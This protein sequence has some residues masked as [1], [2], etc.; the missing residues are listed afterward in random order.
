M[1]ASELKPENRFFGMFVGR[2]KSGKTVAAASFPKPMIILDGDLRA[3]GILGGKSFLRDLDQIEIKQFPPNRGF[4]DMEKEI[5]MIKIMIEGRQSNVKTI[6][7]D[8][9]TST[10]RM[11]INDAHQISKGRLVGKLRM[12]GPADYGYESEASYQIFDYLR[13]IP[14][15]IIISA[16]I[17]DIFGKLNPDDEYSDRGKIGEKLSIRDKIGENIQIYFGEVYKFSKEEDIQ[18]K[19]KHF[20]QFRSE[21][22]GTCFPELPDGKVDITRVNFYDMWSKTIKGGIDV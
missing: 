11:F 18:G 15:N 14:V 8:S 22:A 13:T 17:V 21:I 6:V 16:H 3:A 1:K 2:S 10:T 9:L 7:L 20:V 19:V 5:E 12:S 4:S